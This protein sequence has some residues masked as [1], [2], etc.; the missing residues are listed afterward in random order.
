[1]QTQPAAADARTPGLEE[2][3]GEG[4]HRSSC[5]RIPPLSGAPEE[6][7]VEPENRQQ[8]LTAVTADQTEAMAAY[9]GGRRGRYENR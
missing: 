9:R 6:T 2:V 7:P 1:M 3:P 4:R 5:T 8:A